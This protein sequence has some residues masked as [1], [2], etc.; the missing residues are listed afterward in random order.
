MK[1]QKMSK[2]DKDKL[3]ALARKRFA[4]I[5]AA[6]ADIRNASLEDLK[7]TYNVE[8]GQWPE[9]VINERISD[10]RPC[11]TSNK[12]RKYVAQV[13]NR[14]RDRRLAGKVR[15]IDDNADI[16]TAK[17]IEG[18]IRQIEYTSKADEIYVDAGEK[19]IAGGFGYWRLVTREQDDSF[20]QEVFIEKINNQFSV[21]LDPWGEYAFIRKSISKEEFKDQYP[22]KIAA[23]FD[24]TVAGEEYSQWCDEDR[25]FIAE[26]FYKE[27][28]D[29]TIAECMDI[30]T[31]EKKI[32]ELK[33][34]MTPENLF[35]NGYKILRQKTK[36]A[37]KV[38]WAKINGYE[39]LEEGDW[40]GKN[41]P[42]I[43]VAGDKVNIGGKEYKR[44]LIRDAKDP[45]QMYNYW[46]PLA[47]DTKL[48]TPEGWTTMDEVK[49][50]D[51]LFD[52][53]G[54][55]CHVLGVSPVYSNRK[56]FR[57]TFDDGS[58]IVADADHLWE[59][60]AR[61]EGKSS[62]T[63]PQWTVKTATTE[64]LIPKTHYIYS[65]KPLNL[66]E[67]LLPIHPYI[68]GI[69]LGDGDST[70]AYITSG[71]KDIEEIREII[72]KLGHKLSPVKWD[73]RTGA[74][75]FSVY[76]LF[77][78]LKKLS[79]LRNKHI[80][81]QYLRASHEQRLMLL[82]GLMD[83]DGSIGKS[84]LCNFTTTSDKLRD[85]FAELLRTVG[86]KAIYCTREPRKETF[87]SHS[88]VVH[89]ITSKL[90]QYQFSFSFQK[91][92]TTF[93]LS[94]KKFLQ[95]TKTFFHPRRT[96][97]YSIASIEPI[98]SVAVKCVRVTSKSNLFLAGE[99][100]IP[101]HNTHMTETVALVPKSPYIVTPQEIKGFESIWNVANVKNL[102]YLMFNPQGNRIPKRELPP[103]MQT[104]AGQLL[105][106]AAAD[107]QDTIGMY[108]SSFGEKG[109]ERT[110]I[111]I[112][113]RAGRSDFGT[114]H[115][116]DNFRRAVL[117]TVRHLI[118]I[119]PKIYDTQRIIRILGEDGAGEELVEINKEITIPLTGQKRIINDLTTGKY[120]VVADVKMWSTRRQESA[121][122][123]ASIMQASP[124]IA[125]LILDLVFKYNDFPG[126]SEVEKRIKEHMPSLLG[127]KPG[128]DIDIEQE[129][130]PAGEQNL[131][132]EG[133]GA[134]QWMK[135]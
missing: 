125:P 13:A 109:N 23:S 26:Y 29:K 81:P 54:N 124:N 123:M 116:S 32:V 126:A 132:R 7:F 55:I 19:A 78:E 89:R 72:E 41:I 127:E 82:W 1:K 79:L 48:P 37:K 45:Q 107:I 53:S 65:A 90:K 44:S 30:I 114:F 62:M 9:S 16:K 93:C 71:A 91:N 95:Q 51:R 102:P 122:L 86:I 4:Q 47:L 28:Y 14:E 24:Q 113:S 67:M 106:I 88:N 120:D 10:G 12:L 135:R 17:I 61:R 6:E 94:R 2:K 46:L 118:D 66:P 33:K 38:K 103:Q 110:G 83:S 69:W 108:E 112:R 58:N 43:E 80:P 131:P 52:E 98:E 85:G 104:G 15:P 57:I 64:Q 130:S 8:N 134:P 39:V 34:E 76:G 111:A 27:R 117:E 63:H 87:V 40:V 42:I 100:M 121:E 3:L 97:R 56:C 50:G 60:E 105:Q 35:S 99:A 96:K 74:G 129:Q 75:K 73:K 31:G 18:L 70:S 59:V 128:K 133:E 5:E 25:V 22:G 92:E 11:L 84:Y 119:I 101:T 115:F 21:Y 68:L 49:T 20:E 77:S 36:K